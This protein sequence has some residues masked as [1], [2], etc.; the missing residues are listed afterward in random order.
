[1]KQVRS[2]G[3]KRRRISSRYP[4]IYFFIALFFPLAI[5]SFLSISRNPNRWSGGYLF[6][7]RFGSF[8]LSPEIQRLGEVTSDLGART[9]SSSSSTPCLDNGPSSNPQSA[10]PLSLCIDRISS[11]I[12]SICT[13]RCSRPHHTLASKLFSSFCPKRPLCGA[14]PDLVDTEAIEASH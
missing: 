10:H 13:F 14:T 6:S 5:F 3:G 1:M 2:T 7:F 11:F 4:H 8:S 12:S 9:L